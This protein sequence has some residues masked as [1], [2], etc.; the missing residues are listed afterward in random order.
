MSVGGW[1][2]RT[3]QETAE[4][5]EFVT[6]DDVMAG[7]ADR[8]LLGARAPDEDTMK[9]IMRTLARNAIHDFLI[10]D[11]ESR[12]A[13]KISC[14]VRV[15][16]DGTRV[17]LPTVDTILLMYDMSIDDEV[18][19]ER[20]LLDALTTPCTFVLTSQGLDQDLI[21]RARELAAERADIDVSVVRA[22]NNP[23]M[24]QP[25]GVAKAL[26]QVAGRVAAS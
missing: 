18:Y 22:G 13:D 15:M 26:A 2:L 8:M 7:L 19:P 14:T 4:F 9:S 25:G 1:C 17:R 21:D 6:A 20:G 5:L 24:S 3:R 16:D 23:Q 11:E 10:E 12:F